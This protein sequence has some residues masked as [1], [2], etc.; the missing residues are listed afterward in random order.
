VQN[1]SPEENAKVG[2]ETEALKAWNE[3][4]QKWQKTLA[5]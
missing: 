4:A 3:K 5:K 1:A 2:L